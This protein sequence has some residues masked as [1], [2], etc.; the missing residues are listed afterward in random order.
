MK[1]PTKG[2][3]PTHLEAQLLVAK[4]LRAEKQLELAKKRL[5][6]A[7]VQ[8][9]HER[10]GLKKAKHTAKELRKLAKKAVKQ[11]PADKKPATPKAPSR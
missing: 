1:K 10:R 7:K 6:R 9:K 2:Q 11:L 8:V 3:K 5:H 4:S